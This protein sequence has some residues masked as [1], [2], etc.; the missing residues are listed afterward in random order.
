MCSYCK[1]K[2][3]YFISDY[4]NEANVS[5]N[6]KKIVINKI[7]KENKTSYFPKPFQ[8]IYSIL[9]NNKETYFI[10]LHMYSSNKFYKAIISNE[11]PYT[12]TKTKLILHI[13]NIYK[14]SELEISFML[15]NSRVQLLLKNIYKK[16]LF[17]IWS[18][19]EKDIT[20]TKKIERETYSKYNHTLT[21]SKNN[22]V[23][24]NDTN[25][26]YFYVDE[27][28]L[29]LI[30][31][32]KILIANQLLFDTTLNNKYIVYNQKNVCK[33]TIIRRK[34]NIA[35][36]SI[37]DKFDGYSVLYKEL[38]SKKNYFDIKFREIINLSDFTYYIKNKDYARN[39]FDLY[40][41]ELIINKIQLISSINNHILNNHPINN[42]IC[43]IPYLE[44]NGLFN[45]VELVLHYCEKC[46]V[47]F[48]LL[49][50][51][52]VQ[53]EKLNVDPVDLLIPIIN[54]HNKNIFNE[55]LFNHKES[56]LKHFGYNVGS[57]EN[58]S[59]K[60]RHHILD[61]L[62]L[63]HIV[64]ELEIKNLLTLFIRYQ[65]KRK[66]MENATRKWKEDLI[67]INNMICQNNK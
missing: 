39:P 24:H 14:L 55:N 38:S 20:L 49:E 42:V 26:S 37:V 29:Y 16:D 18:K 1:Y 3:S 58:L 7:I 43:K 48:D 47:Y 19:K 30:L 44:K 4:S 6:N 45:T 15:K 60:Q 5:L 28:N 10:Y 46:D 23:L 57:N 22:V 25:N 52:L 50:S 33:F 66:G 11:K 35:I 34:D 63:N 41:S 9:K 56:I 2:N 13:E 40:Q 31:Y 62:I 65:G 53:L 61:N 12:L 27:F 36:L 64:S 21:D 54:E 8:H 51:F 17:P 32:K 59:K 67:Y